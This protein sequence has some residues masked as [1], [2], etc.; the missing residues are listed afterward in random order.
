MAD[1]GSL[2]HDLDIARHGDVA[3]LTVVGPVAESWNAWGLRPACGWR[4]VTFRT[5][6]VTS[7]RTP[8]SDENSCRTFPDLIEVTAALERRQENAAKRALPAG[9][10]DAPAVSATNVAFRLP[11]PPLLFRALGFFSSLPVL[12]VDGHVVSP[13]SYGRNG[14]GSSQMSRGM[15]DLSSAGRSKHRTRRRLEGH[16]VVRDRGPRVRRSRPEP[17]LPLRLPGCARRARRP[18]LPA[19]SAATPWA[20]GVDLREPLEAHAATT[21]KWRCLRVGDGD[22]RVVELAFTWAT[23]AVMFCARDGECAA[24]HVPLGKIL[25]RYPDAERRAVSHKPASGRSNSSPGRITSSCPR[26]ASSC[27][28][29]VRIGV[30]ALADRLPPCDRRRW[31]HGS[32]GLLVRQVWTRRSAAMFSLAVISF[33]G[34]TDAVDIG[35]RDDHALVGRDVDTAIRAMKFVLPSSRNWHGRTCSISTRWFPPQELRRPQIARRQTGG[36]GG[37]PVRARATASSDRFPKLERLDA[38][39]RPAETIG[40]PAMHPK[41]KRVHQ[42]EP[43]PS[44]AQQG[45]GHGGEAEGERSMAG[46][47]AL[48]DDLKPDPPRV[49]GVAGERPDGEGLPQADHLRNALH[50]RCAMPPCREDLGSR[51]AHHAAAPPP[52]SVPCPAPP[53]ASYAPSRAVRSASKPA[54]GPPR[55]CRGR[56]PR[57]GRRCPPTRATGAASPARPTRRS[58]K[59]LSI[60]LIAAGSSTHG[61]SATAPPIFHFNRRKAQAGI[62]PAR[63]AHSILDQL[64]G[65]DRGSGRRSRPAAAQAPPRAGADRRSAPPARSWCAGARVASADHMPAVGDDPQ[66][67]HQ[68]LDLAEHGVQPHRQP[69]KG[70]T[71]AIAFANQRDA[72]RRV[73]LAAASATE[74]MLLSRPHDIMA[75]TNPCTDPSISDSTTAKPTH[76]R[77]RS[78]APRSDRG[79]PT[80]KPVIANRMERVS[81]PRARPRRPLPQHGD[82]EWRVGQR[83]RQMS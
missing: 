11:S 62:S 80:N 68:L 13:L 21:T 34:R 77:S 65:R 70:I 71:V 58:L 6:S 54:P 9:Q 17:A 1:H 29:R 35:Q 78:A 81:P 12:C 60:R 69:V 55:R 44:L 41:T 18:S 46:C 5:M 47:K 83:H 72:T 43:I 79:R 26:S 51:T 76:A 45:E 63:R 22:H 28:L 36:V 14:D 33:I 73:A 42:C 4:A 15:A 74:T 23:P 20:Y 57:P 7:S 66:L 50:H 64:G 27:P 59:A 30:R 25:T 8:A 52:R 38:L 53:R 3:G 19:S 75:G 37:R 61:G 48:Q 16:A 10:A 2:V 56:D 40:R 31:F 32:A 67:G 39:Q 24:V 49:R 82:T